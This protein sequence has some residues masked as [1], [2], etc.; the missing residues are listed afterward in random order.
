MEKAPEFGDRAAD[1]ESGSFF[2]NQL[3][4]ASAQWLDALMPTGSFMLFLSFMLYRFPAFSNS[5]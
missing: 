3:L 2:F 1:P 4:V 5:L